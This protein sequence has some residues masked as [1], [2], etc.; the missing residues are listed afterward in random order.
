MIDFRL[1]AGRYAVACGAAAL[2]TLGLVGAGRA[3][4][5]FPFDQELVLDVRP[6]P[7]VK[8]VP[9]LSVAA[10][11]EAR[12]DLWCRTVG[13]RV[14]LADRAIRIEPAPLTD[15]LPRYMSEGQCTPERMQADQDV[16]A[17]LAQVTDWRR[18]GRAVVLVGPK[19]LKFRPSD[20]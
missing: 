3:T 9:I 1:V 19:T 7:P 20:H 16:L 17:D 2:F 10:N 6:M 12:I 11:G 13:G 15:A 4:E 5:P 14:E 8:R 18:Q